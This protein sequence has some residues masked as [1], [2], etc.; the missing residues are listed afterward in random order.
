MATNAAISI[1]S[2]I[3][4]S[5]NGISFSINADM[6]MTK[7]G[8]QQ[9]LEETTGLASRAYTATTQV[10]LVDVSAEDV[11]ANGANKVYI[12]N[13]TLDKSQHLSLIHI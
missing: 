13:T 7:A 6:T 8:T 2:D 9:D 4:D 10:V 1:T 12:R 11:T 5:A 3:T